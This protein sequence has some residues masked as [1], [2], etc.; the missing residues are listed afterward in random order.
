MTASLCE[1]KFRNG[2]TCGKTFEEEVY[3]TSP[4]CILHINFPDES[5]P[6]YND[7]IN[8]KN[9]K[10][11]EKAQA[12]DFNFEGA[13]VFEINFLRLGRDDGVAFLPSSF[14]CL[15]L[16]NRDIDVLNFCDAHIKGNVTLMEATIQGNISFKKAKREGDVSFD[17]AEIQKDVWFKFATIQ[18]DASFDLAKIYGKVSFVEAE[19]QGNTSLHGAKGDIS[20]IGAKIC[21]DALFDKAKVEG[22]ASFDGAKI[23]GD[24]FFCRYAE[25]NGALTFEG[26]AFKDPSVQEEACRKAK[27]TCEQAGDRDIADYHFYR[28]MEAKR[29]RKK[30]YIR[31]PEAPLLQYGLWFG[32]YPFRLLLNFALIFAF[33]VCWFWVTNGVYTYSGLT[34]SMGFS[35]LNILIPGYG[36]FATTTPY[37]GV[38]VIVETAIGAFMWPAF[39]VTFARKYMR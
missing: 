13:K 11:Q 29:K 33:F 24:N 15:P 22:D 16:K 7:I 1:Y 26:A 21:G 4:Y 34:D 35:F 5:D 37:H 31:Y 32:V 30:W 23:M 6:K 25:I 38:P 2:E 12:G 19:I 27:Q 9:A 36:I 17:D 10:V 28:E 20:F 3:E 8:K 39:I 14:Q 18:G